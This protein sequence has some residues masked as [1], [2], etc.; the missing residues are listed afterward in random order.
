MKP[1]K[2]KLSSGTR[3]YLLDEDGVATLWHAP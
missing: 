2:L 3:R 1:R